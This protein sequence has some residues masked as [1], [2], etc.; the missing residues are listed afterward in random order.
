MDLNNIIDI[1][2]Q[3]KKRANQRT[4]NY[5]NTLK[6]LNYLKKELL[7]EIYQEINSL[8]IVESKEFKF[9]IYSH[10]STS[11]STPEEAIVKYFN[12]IKEMF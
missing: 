1:C 5:K 7:K 4:F 10:T 8:K 11:G 3:D 6:C 2:C 12:S 9:H